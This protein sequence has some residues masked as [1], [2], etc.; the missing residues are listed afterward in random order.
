MA[1]NTVRWKRV[2]LAGFAEERYVV[3]VRALTFEE[4]HAVLRLAR[5][6]DWYGNVDLIVK[7][8]SA[9][10]KGGLDA[11]GTGAFTV[12]IAAREIWLLTLLAI[13]A[14][15]KAI[16]RGAGVQIAMPRIRRYRYEDLA[17]Q[18]CFFIS[19]THARTS[20]WRVT[21]ATWW[22]TASPT[23]PYTVES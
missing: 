3:D 4:V 21:C 7:V 14:R 13:V 16:C 9:G 12:A 15:A 5:D 11:L 19:Q 20:T 2:T 10:V 1:E 8:A 17:R 18:A 6:S 23:Y 22:E